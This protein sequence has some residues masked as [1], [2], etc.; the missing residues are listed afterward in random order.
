MLSLSIGVESNMQETPAFCYQ[1]DLTNSTWPGVR[2]SGPGSP[3]E[4][5]EINV[6]FFWR[7]ISE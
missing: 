4:L 5:E 1:D 2:I 3:G 7:G 6:H